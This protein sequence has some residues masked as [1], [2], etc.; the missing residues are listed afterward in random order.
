[1]GRRKKGPIKLITT[2]IARKLLIYWNNCMGNF[3]PNGDYCVQMVINVIQS[4]PLKEPGLYE[5][6]ID[7]IKFLEEHHIQFY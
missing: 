2:N 6:Y 3:V 1:M 4:R 5:Y 7:I